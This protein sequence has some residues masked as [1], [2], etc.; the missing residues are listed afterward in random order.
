L[1]CGKTIPTPELDELGNIIRGATEVWRRELLE[2]QSNLNKKCASCLCIAGSGNW[3]E[4]ASK[5]VMWLK[6]KEDIADIRKNL[7]IFS[8]S[9]LIMSDVAQKQYYLNY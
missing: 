7:H 1:P 8:K 6:E 3:L 2:F 9:I 4:D 5:I